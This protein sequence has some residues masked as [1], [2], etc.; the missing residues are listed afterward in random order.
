MFCESV[1]L[2]MNPR[3]FVEP[4]IQ[5][6]RATLVDREAHHLMHVLRLGVDSQVTLFDGSG[7]EFEACVTKINRSDVELAVLARNNVERELARSITLGVALPKG[8]RQKW[9]VEKV[10]ELGV[11]RLVP[12]ETDRGVA[13][14][15]S[16]ALVRLRHAVIEASKQCRRNRLME[17]PESMALPEFLAAISDG[18]GCYLAHPGGEVSPDQLAAAS[19]ASE[20][21]IAIGPEG[22]FTDE[23]VVAAKT[24][25]WQI[26]D[27]GPRIL[28]IETAATVLTVMASLG[29]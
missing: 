23:E 12:L 24:A 26:V 11:A 25:G 3:F 2:A 29:S 17:I 8:D 10:T 21:F 13:Q 1:E 27:L 4:L 5:G 19:M 16:K 6:D 9:M 22:G 14:P 15:S 18:A 20:T 7:A 28:R